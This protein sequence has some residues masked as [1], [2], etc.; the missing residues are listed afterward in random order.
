MIECFLCNYPFWCNISIFGGVRLVTSRRTDRLSRGATPRQ[1]SVGPQK[2]NHNHFRRNMEVANR[3]E[4][5]KITNDV[6]DVPRCTTTR[7]TS[8]HAAHGKITT[9]TFDETRKLQTELKPARLQFTND[10]M[11]V[12]RR[13]TTR[14]TSIHA[15]HGKITT[16]APLYYP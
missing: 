11:D 14:D 1:H 15:A 8:I 7:D 9:I 2:N 6:M 12:P 3:T 16:M 13:T 5:S 4:A 10:V